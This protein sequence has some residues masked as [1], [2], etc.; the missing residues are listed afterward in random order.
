MSN[1]S[2]RKRTRKYMIDQLPNRYYDNA[3]RIG[4]L[5]K[6][7]ESNERVYGRADIRSLA[8]R[9]KREL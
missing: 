2:D 8:E 9:E 1:K 6:M 5:T 4:Y 3:N 7:Q